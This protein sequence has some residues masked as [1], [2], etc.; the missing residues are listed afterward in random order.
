MSA[1][2]EVLAQRIDLLQSQLEEYGGYLSLVERAEGFFKHVFMSEMQYYEVDSWAGYDEI[3]A[4]IKAYES[5]GW[6]GAA[7]AGSGLAGALNLTLTLL[8]I[9]F[10][11]RDRRICPDYRWLLLFWGGSISVLTFLVTPLSWTRY[12][13]PILPFVALMS[14]NSIVALLTL[15]RARITVRDN[16]MDI[17]V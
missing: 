6:S 9:G 11:L 2:S 5:S 10:L 12:Y 17:R 13:L 16:D 1:A 3:T 7:I 15:I 14:A 4:Q 8:G